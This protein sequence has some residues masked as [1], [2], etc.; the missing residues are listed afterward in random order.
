MS[1]REP[2]VKWCRV[3]K[4]IVRSLGLALSEEGSVEGRGQQ[5]HNFTHI[6]S[7]LTVLRIG[8]EGTY[9]MVQ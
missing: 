7:G 5:G 9:L 8:C 1:G 6:L 3:L 4:V 2:D